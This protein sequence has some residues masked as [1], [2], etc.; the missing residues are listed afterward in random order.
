MRWLWLVLVFAAFSADAAGQRTV[1]QE[2]LAG[3][4]PKAATMTREV[5]LH[6]QMHGYLDALIELQVR[7]Q[8]READWAQYS[9]ALW[10]DHE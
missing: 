10:A 2:Q 7:L 3:E 4:S 6:Q 9:R 5:V 1:T 8:Q